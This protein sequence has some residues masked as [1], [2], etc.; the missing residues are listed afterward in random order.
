M[1]S[2]MS[3]R[4]GRRSYFTFADDLI[5][6]DLAERQ[7]RRSLHAGAVGYGVRDLW[8]ASG[9][10]VSATVQ[11]DLEETEGRLHLRLGS[12]SEATIQLCTTAQALGGVRWWMQCPGC[13]ERCRKLYYERWGPWGCRRC[14]QLRYRSQ[15]LGPA[16]RAR[17]RAE[18][19]FE[20]AG[21][22]RWVAEPPRPRGMRRRTFTRLLGKAR[23][24][25]AEWTRLGVLPQIE[26]ARRFKKRI[27]K[28]LLKHLRSHNGT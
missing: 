20:R 11:Y 17:S 22:F 12:T 25:E 18:K 13:A 24:Y 28:Q 10:A 5:C 15:H 3:G 6:V 9:R 26:E 4:H 14:L 27:R 1:G 2:C 7:M 21:T 23:H 19:Y 8:S 16:L